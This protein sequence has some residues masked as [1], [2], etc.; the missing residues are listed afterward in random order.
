MLICKNKGQVFP[1][2]YNFN[3][4]VYCGRDMV[5]DFI[6]IGQA[7]RV[8]LQLVWPLADC[9]YHVYTD[10]YV[11][12]IYLVVYAVLKFALVQRD[13]LIKL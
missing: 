9:N 2:S 1:C 12:L 3:F 5:A 10:R 7:T 4:E 6:E 13:I 11:L 8:V